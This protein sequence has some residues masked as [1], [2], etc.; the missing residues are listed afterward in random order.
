MSNNSKKEKLQEL[1]DKDASVDQDSM[2]TLTAEEGEDV[3]HYLDD[4]QEEVVVN[5]CIPG[6]LASL[7]AQDSPIKGK[8]DLME[9]LRDEGTL[10]DIEEEDLEDEL[11]D[12]LATEF[13]ENWRE[14]DDL[15]ETE[16]EQYDYK[17]GFCTVRAYVEL[18]VHQL[19]ELPE[20]S[21]TNFDIKVNTSM[22]ELTIK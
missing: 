16:T 1:M 13:V 22:G 2:L 12:I 20:Y 15:I 19:L 6:Y 8:E 11:E 7:F 4:H 17:R 9:R 5:S 21:F 10:D 3:F 18:P 14:H